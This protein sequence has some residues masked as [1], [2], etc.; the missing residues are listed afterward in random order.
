MHSHVRDWRV[1]DLLYSRALTGRDLFFGK[2]FNRGL[3]RIFRRVIKG[4]EKIKPRSPLDLV[5]RY[6]EAIDRPGEAHFVGDDGGKHRHVLTL[7]GKDD[8]VSV[9]RHRYTAGTDVFE[10]SGAEQWS[11]EDGDGIGGRGDAPDCVFQFSPQT[12]VDALALG[13]HVAQDE[14]GAE[15]R[16]GPGKIG[17]GDQMAAR[18]TGKTEVGVGGAGGSQKRIAAK[19]R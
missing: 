5:D 17:G 12:R 7:Y 6:G 9:R 3:K 11:G 14:S 15:G 16:L 13:Y 19:G 10:I 1:G 18:E 4:A 8:F 2:E